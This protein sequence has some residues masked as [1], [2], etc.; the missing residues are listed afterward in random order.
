MLAT[1]SISRYRFS[2][3]LFKYSTRVIKRSW[4][5]KKNEITQ[6]YAFF[7]ISLYN[8]YLATEDILLVPFCFKKFCKCAV[9][10]QKL[11]KKRTTEYTNFIT[12]R[13]SNFKSSFFLL[14]MSIVNSFIEEINKKF[15]SACK[16]LENRFCSLSIR[17]YTNS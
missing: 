12:F 8:S 15:C 6:V 9:N 4:N 16:M 5:Q 11:F 10:H 13:N 7:V 1:V 2:S 3:A 14:E 17:F